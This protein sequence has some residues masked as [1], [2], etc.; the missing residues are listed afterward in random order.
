MQPV[1]PMKTYQVIYYSRTE[2]V[3][4]ETAL[5]ALLKAFPVEEYPLVTLNRIRDNTIIFVTNLGTFEVM[6][7]K[8]G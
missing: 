3:Q 5:G 7:I 1:F 6:E 4:A 2:R 8:N